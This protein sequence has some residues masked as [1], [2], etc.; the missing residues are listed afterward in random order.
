MPERQNRRR[1]SSPA[2]QGED[3]WIEITRLTMKEAR[4]IEAK[5]DD[6]DVDAY[7]EVAKIFQRYIVGWNWVNDDGVPLPLPKDNIDVIGDLTDQEFEFISEALTGD[8]AKQK[9]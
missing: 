3:S 4:E 7:T 5:K 2:V 8:E 6:P 9:N 1:V